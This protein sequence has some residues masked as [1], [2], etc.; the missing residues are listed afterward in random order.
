MSQVIYDMRV[1][2]E[3]YQKLVRD[4]AQLE[5]VKTLLQTEFPDDT[6]QLIAIKNILGIVEDTPEPIPDEP[7]TGDEVTDGQT[8]GA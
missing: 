5:D 4:S 1:P 8:T 3:E 6:C 7:I 2:Y